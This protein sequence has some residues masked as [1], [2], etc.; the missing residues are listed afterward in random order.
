MSQREAPAI[1]RIGFTRL[2][3]DSSQAGLP[4]VNII[5]VHGLRGH[6]QNT[7]EYHQTGA[8]S[9]NTNTP[10]KRDRFRAILRPHRD[11]QTPPGVGENNND[12][13]R[14]SSTEHKVFWPRDYL[15]ED[16]PEAEVW[17][18]GYN[19][20]V[21]EA[22]FK[23]NNRNSISQH[24]QD[25]YVKLERTIDNQMPIVFVAHSLGGIIVKK[26][27]HRSELC[28]SRT[29]LVV[30]LGT[31]H[32]GSAT[33]GW[34]VVASNLA[35][36]AL[37][38]SNKQ[39]VRTLEPNSEVLDD[40]RFEFVKIMQKY[41]IKVH[42]F[43]EAKAI[44]GVKGLHGKVVED[45]SSKMDLPPLETVETIDA[46]HMEMV[47]CEDKTDPRYQAIMGVL[48]QFVRNHFEAQ[49]AGPAIQIGSQR[50]LSL[51]ETEASQHTPVNKPRHY[52]PF[53]KNKSFT[54]RAPVL[55]QIK[56]R[57]FISKECQKLAVFGLGGVGKTQVALSLAYWA[58]ENQPDCSIFW[59][60]ALSDKGFEQAYTD[61]ASLL[62][63][64]IKG[65]EDLK[66]AVRRYLESE[67][68]GRWLLIVDNVDDM[69]ILLKSGGI[70]TYLPKSENGIILFTTRFREIAL[71]VAETDI[72]NLHEMSVEEAT[73]FLRKVLINKEPLG[74]KP[75]IEELLRELTYLP[76]AISQA[77]AY[78]NRNQVSVQKYLGLLQNT[79]QDLINLMN[80]EFHDKSRYQGTRNAVAATWLVS[81][82]QIRKSDS[83]AGQLLSFMSCIEPKAIPQSILPKPRVE[84]EMEQ[85][86]GTLCGYA[87]LVRREDGD[88]FDMH[89]LVHIAARVWIQENNTMAEIKM[90]AVKHITSVFRKT[91]QGNRSFAREY[92]PHAQ[93]ALQISKEYQNKERF[94]LF[95]HVGR[96]LFDNRRFKEA[97]IALAETAFWRKQHLPEE[98]W[99][100][101]T[102]GYALA[103]AYLHNRQIKEAIELFEHVVA[104][105]QKT[106]VEEDHSRLTSEHALAS[107][108]LNNGQIKE[109][110][111]LLEHHVVAIRQ[112][113][114]V[115]EDRSRLTSEHAL[116]RAY[117][118]NR[119]IKE[120]IGLLERVVAVYKTLEMS[121]EDRLVSQDLLEKAYDMLNGAESGPSDDD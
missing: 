28:Q 90:N 60:P 37:H 85:A 70:G 87:F 52:L 98:G 65:D 119:Q 79:E 29:K 63:V 7:W 103:N 55:D 93:H 89:R 59:V 95:F 19:A 31:P 75:M 51:G 80:R 15:L 42:S 68:A 100:R 32:R 13:T 101:L 86:I 17:T 39:I 14:G 57:L 116:A 117:L 16:M 8:N 77:A 58:K 74:D 83:Y 1:Q 26:A 71:A 114:L 111:E 94:D 110:I 115:E 113:T 84:E 121:D 72:I 73:E 109:A 48:K 82:D 104:I 91:R 3:R 99:D 12:S 10:R 76:L 40:I 49:D 88:M 20:D 25:L 41:R 78:I 4:K 107:A 24:A 50:N 46:N 96:C 27:I 62:D 2:S 44:T 102:S 21:V 43:Q 47:R 6:P 30:F 22:L 66:V 118:E 108:Y 5:F 33:A 56:E 35:N 81:F 9:R 36:L 112:K 67:K 97:V 38:D 64:Q 18:Y 11:A 54:G 92:L 106:L 34:G 120:A 23:A 45:D 105:R 69:D 53:L 61:M